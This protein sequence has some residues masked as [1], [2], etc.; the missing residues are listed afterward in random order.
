M[1]LAGYLGFP[2]FAVECYAAMSSFS[3][4]RGGRGWQ[5]FDHAKST[6][7]ALAP[8]LKALAALGALAFNL[9]VLYL[10]DQRVVQSLAD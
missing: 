5:A 7:P 3:I 6:R 8:W 9:G 1:P 10:M 4:L 2:P